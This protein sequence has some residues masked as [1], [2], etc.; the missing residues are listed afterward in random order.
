MH[1]RFYICY[2]HTKITIPHENKLIFL[3]LKD[4]HCKYYTLNTTCIKFHKLGNL[5]IT[6]KMI[7]TTLT[8]I[9]HSTNSYN[10]IKHKHTL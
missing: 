2:L 10:T 1:K 4:R 8:T 5:M 9:S 3:Y 7:P 6:K